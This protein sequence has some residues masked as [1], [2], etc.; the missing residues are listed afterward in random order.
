M[1]NKNNEELYLIIRQGS[2]E[3]AKEAMAILEERNQTLR[4]SAIKAAAPAIMIRNLSHGAGEHI[5]DALDKNGSASSDAWT[6]IPD[7]E[8]SR[9]AQTE[10]DKGGKSD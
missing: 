4:A 7:S 6:D 2:E 8:I 3:E 10:E 1:E 5:S 9:P